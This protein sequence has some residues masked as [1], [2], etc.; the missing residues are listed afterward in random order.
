MVGCF[1]A[2][3]AGRLLRQLV[4][5]FVPKV[6]SVCLHPLSQTVRCEEAGGEGESV[7]AVGNNGS[8]SL[9]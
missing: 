1:Y 6:V 8:L 7:S 4:G 9:Q 2:I 3:V 5:K